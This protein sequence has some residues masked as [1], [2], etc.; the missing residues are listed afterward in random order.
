MPMRNIL[1]LIILLLAGCNTPPAIQYQ[2]AS[3][4]L[5]EFILSNGKLSC[6][7]LP[8]ASGLLS[9]LEYLPEH[10]PLFVP[11]NFSVEKDDLLPT[12]IN[13]GATGSRELL[14]G[15]KQFHN[16]P[17]T[18]TGRK[19]SPDAVSVTMQ[20]RFFCGS[21]LIAEKTLELPGND[22]VLLH[23]RFIL[24]NPS[25][26]AVEISLWCNLIAKMGKKQI[27]PVL[28]PAKGGV[29]Q[30]QNRGITGF[31]HDSVYLED[32]AS[33]VDVF[34]APGRPWIARFSRE[35]P[36]VLVM[37]CSTPG[38]LGPGAR[39]Y[40][41]KRGERTMEMIFAPVSIAPGSSH[42]WDIDYIFFPSMRMVRDVAGIFAVNRVDS[43]D[44]TVL[45]L[46]ACL[47][48]PAGTLRLNSGQVIPLPDMRP[49]R[50]YTIRLPKT[51]PG[52]AIS[53]TLPGNVDFILNPMTSEKD[54]TN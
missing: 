47:S 10:R 25:E 21:P 45:E 17:M 38:A 3:G 53:G 32:D 52:T 1:F 42:T 16:L 18:V 20:Q 35:F 8:E 28:M 34:T 40:S 37:R 39:F 13:T 15:V 2:E 6:S 33:S 54:I 50:I 22:A 30:V 11:V 5:K 29:Y 27:D 7:V 43:A 51:D 31:A 9:R 46:E 12:R 14:W 4:Q 36:G 49:G 44:S 24:C 41:Y 26:Q 23:S 48:A 19:E